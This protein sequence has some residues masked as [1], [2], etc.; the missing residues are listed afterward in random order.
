LLIPSFR[1][2]LSDNEYIF[3]LY[4]CNVL[5]R[6][7]SLQTRM[8]L[9]FLLIPSSRTRLNDSGNEYVSDYGTMQVFMQKPALSNTRRSYIHCMVIIV[10]QNNVQ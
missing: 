4:I 7:S 8:K 10:A 1:T 2:R 9:D 3:P 6:A 5:Y